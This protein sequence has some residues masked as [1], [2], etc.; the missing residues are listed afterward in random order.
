LPAWQRINYWHAYLNRELNCELPTDLVNPLEWALGVHALRR[1]IDRWPAYARQADPVGALDRAIAQGERLLAAQSALSNCGESGPVSA[2]LEKYRIALVRS[3]EELTAAAIVLRNQTLTGG[4]DVRLD[5]PA[6]QSTSYRPADLLVVPCSD[7]GSCGMKAE[8]EPSPALFGLF[9][10]PFLVADQIGA[11]TLALCYDNVRWVD[12]RAEI[13]QVRQPAMANYFGRL[14]FDLHGRMS[15]VE[16]DLFVQRLTSTGEFEYLFGG[17]SP[18][19][20]G[21]ECPRHLV[22]SQVLGELPERRFQLVPRRLTY[23]TAERT[24]P[25]RA[26]AQH[27]SDGEQWREA[28]AAGRSVE[29]LEA[30]E[31]AD[32]VAALNI[33]IEEL[34]QR[35][36]GTLY[37]WL[38]YD[39][40]M[41]R[42]ES[43]ESLSQATRELDLFKAM[44]TR[45]ARLAAPISVTSSASR[46]ASLRGAEQL[47]DRSQI[48]RYRGNRIA[49][50]SLVQI[51]NSQ[52]A[53]A[54]VAWRSSAA[55]GRTQAEPMV[56][57]GLLELQALRE[58][59]LGMAPL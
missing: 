34:W 39:D 15:G 48:V 11:G 1:F 22:D 5:E 56:V 19:V 55:A 59:L 13:P 21:D 46:R 24:S 30:K 33:R 36:N 35:W 45:V 29:T 7:E 31:P 17:N 4:A 37:G 51:G 49:A 2:L 20:L 23:V 6:T 53:D 58:R 16:G 10:E 44:T 41:N 54:A 8:L 47:L 12:R 25:A 28:L 38:L 43:A 26:F 18:A 57:A 52:Y 42:N 32:F 27:W 50:E 14:S 3:A 40:P 9:A